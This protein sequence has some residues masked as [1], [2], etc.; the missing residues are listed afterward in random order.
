MNNHPLFSL[1]FYFLIFQ[2]VSAF[3]ILDQCFLKGGMR[4]SCEINFVYAHSSSLY[5]KGLLAT[6]NLNNNIIVI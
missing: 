4:D 6:T 3:M 1:N 5:S 2:G